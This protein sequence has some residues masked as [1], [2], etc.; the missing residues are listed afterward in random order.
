[1]TVGTP[2]DLA[3][4]TKLFTSVAAVQQIERGT[5]GIDARVGAYL[6]DFTRAAPARHHRTAAAHPHLRAAARTPAVR[7]RRRRAAAGDAPGGAAGRRARHVPL[8]RPEHAAPPVRPGTHHRPHARRPRPRRH[9][10]AAGHDRDG[11]RAVPRGGG[12]G[13]PAAAVGQGGPG[14]AAGRGARRERLG[15]GRGG[16]PRGPV[17]HRARPRGVL[18]RPPGRRLLRP[19]P[20]PRPRLRRAPLH[21]ARPR[22]LARPAV[23]HGRPG[24]PGRGRP[25]GL[26]RH[27][28]RPR[29]GD[30]HVPGPPRQHG[31]PTPRAARTTRP[32]RAAGGA[33]RPGRYRRGRSRA[34]PLSP[35]SAG[36]L[37]P[38]TPAR[39]IAG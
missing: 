23:V 39:R 6:P 27:V 20:H 18:P 19:R 7:L 12:D 29:P 24:G 32:G 3:S 5:L 1:M 9:H 37:G 4:L 33:G 35:E 14:H 28:P 21:P 15:T 38:S 2:F 11:F 22:L 30:G 36:A 8:L 17:L 13:G 16:G 26:H 10:P 34:A 31:P 25:H